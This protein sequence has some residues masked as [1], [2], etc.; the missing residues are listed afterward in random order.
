MRFFLRGRRSQAGFSLIELM[1]ATF[2]L[3][4]GMLGSLALIIAS[5][6]DNTRNKMDTAATLIAQMVIEQINALPANSSTITSITIT[7]GSGTDR[8]FDV[9]PGGATLTSANNIDWTASAVSGYNTVFAGQDGMTYD[10]RWNIQTIG[11][12]KRV[13][14]SARQRM[15]S[16]GGRMFVIPATIKTIT[17]P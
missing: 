1:I 5:I 14:V 11:M 2:I 8:S 15:T 4:V 16:R 17:G 7:D 3:A 10:V 13:I 9:R 6:T 12:M